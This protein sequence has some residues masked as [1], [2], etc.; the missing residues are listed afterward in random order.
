MGPSWPLLSPGTTARP[1]LLSSRDSRFGGKS[2]PPFFPGIWMFLQMFGEGPWRGACEPWNTA[3]AGGLHYP[4]SGDLDLTRRTW[5]SLLQCNPCQTSRLLAF[6][7]C[8]QHRPPERESARL[9]G[10]CGRVCGAGAVSGGPRV[11]L[12]CS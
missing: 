1:P 11:V 5:T 8:R 12:L 7:L 9:S 10:V 6:F 3:G 4:G 2:S